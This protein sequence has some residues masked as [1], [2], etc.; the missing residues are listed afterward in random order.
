VEVSEGTSLPLNTM[1][2]RIDTASASTQGQRTDDSRA[3][4]NNKVRHREK[5]DGSS[6]QLY[7]C[8]CS[9]R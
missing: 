7:F 6:F 9:T 5:F 2:S 4:G 8:A 1:N 3:S